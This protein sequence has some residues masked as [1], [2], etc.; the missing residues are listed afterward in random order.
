MPHRSKR[1][2]KKNRTGRTDRS[3]SPSGDALEAPLLPG[4][5]HRSRSSRNLTR[6]ETVNVLQN[7]ETSSNAASTHQEFHCQNIFTRS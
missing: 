1:G 6:D 2:G 4:R 7:T 3:Q 5:I